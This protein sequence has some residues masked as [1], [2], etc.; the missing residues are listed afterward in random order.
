MIY[1][2]VNYTILSEISPSVRDILDIGCGTGSLGTVIKQRFSTCKVFGITYQSS[3]AAIAERSL[4]Q[5]FQFNLNAL[6]SECFSYHF[7]CV[8]CSHILEHLYTPQEFLRQIK[9][10]FNDDGILIVALPNVLHWKQ[11]LEFLKGNFKYTDGGLMDRTHFR[12]FDW[13]TAYELVTGAGY[14]VT[15]RYADGYFPLPGIRKIFPLLAAVLDRWASRMMPGLFGV[16]FI[17]V[18]E[19]EKRNE[20]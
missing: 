19:P 2:G 16:Q 8:I 15:R 4:D 12:F 6:E 3:E 7:D 9:F 5:V 13:D 10:T 17:L 11:R 18:A 20:Q 1:E 14:R